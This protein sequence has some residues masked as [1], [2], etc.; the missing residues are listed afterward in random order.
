MTVGCLGAL[1]ALDMAQAWL[2][3]HGGGLAAV[4]VAERWTYTVDYTSMANMGLWGHSDGAAAAVVGHKTEHQAKAYFAGAEFVS[5]SDLN[6]TVLIQYGGTRYPTAPDGVTPF[7]RKL[8]GLD[9][10][11]LRQRYSDGYRHSLTAIQ[12]QFD[13][14]P[15]KVIINQTS[16]LFLH[17]IAAVIDIPIE[18]FVLTGH[19]TGHVGSADIVIGLD[20]VLRSAD[21]VNEPYLIMGSTPYAFGAGLVTAAQS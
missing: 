19:D 2:A 1:S 11:D 18:N 5:Q 8:V 20:R 14:D 12:D 7:E 3:G 17:L 10:H 9:R 13:L 6:G 16:T 4:V 15:K 21:G